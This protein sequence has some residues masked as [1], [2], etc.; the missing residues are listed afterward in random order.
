MMTDGKDGVVTQAPGTGN[1][2]VAVVS[3]MSSHVTS[4]TGPAVIAHSIAGGGVS[5]RD[6]GAG[7]AD[8]TTGFYNPLTFF[9]LGEAS[10][11]VVEVIGSTVTAGDAPAIVAKTAGDIDKGN[12]GG[13]TAKGYVNI[14][15]INN[16]SSIIPSVVTNSSA[17]HPTIWIENVGNTRDQ[18]IVGLGTTVQNTVAGA[19]AIFNGYDSPGLTLGNNGTIIGDIYTNSSSL[20]AS[21]I[22]NGP[23]GVLAPYDAIELGGGLLR[24]AGTIEPGGIGRFHATEIDGDLVQTSTGE[25]R[26]DLDAVAGKVDTL[27]V[28]GTAA[29]AG[30]LAFAPKTLLPGS[31][32]V[33]VADGGAAFTDA[34]AAGKT[35]VFRFT[36]ALDGDRVSLS[37]EADFSADGAESADR[38]SVATHLQRVWDAGGQGFAGG[39]ASLSTVADGDAAGYADALDAMSGQAVAAIGYARFL[40]SQAFAQSTYSCPRFEEGGVMRTE[41]SCGWLRVR[42]AWLE[43]DASGDDPAFDLDAVTTSIG[44]QTRIDDGLFLGGALGWESSRLNDQDDSTRV[45]GDSYLAAVSLKRETGPWTL[46]GALD[47]GWGDYDSTRKIVFGTTSE[48]AKGAPDAF[49]AGAHLRAAYEIPR[50]VWYMEPAL[51]VDLVYVKLDGYT[52]KGAGEFD[53]AVD[54]ADTVVLAGTPWLKLGRRVDL[55]NGGVLDAFVSGGV[56]F[57]TGEDFST[58]ARLAHAPSRGGDFTTEIDNPSVIGRVSAGIDLYATDRVEL[59]LQ[60]DGSFADGQTS[61]GGQFRFSYFF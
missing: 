25:I 41:A 27:H 9:G 55:A 59:R 21:L 18:I 43:R 45:E 38:R 44:G 2:G 47:L 1:A 52:E 19:Y 3:L 12:D 61:N 51:D 16:Q 7:S 39:F 29:L 11:A 23:K 10:D 4:T 32:K 40:G 30:G 14:Q 46:T 31:H 26:F 49:T 36:P 5:P 15:S 35:Q 34:L 20:A 33:L 48:T 13:T 58:I 60:Y 28:T 53:L 8:V 50:G 37:T 22:S 56:S 17:T 42:G 54:S 6:G 24:N 57:S